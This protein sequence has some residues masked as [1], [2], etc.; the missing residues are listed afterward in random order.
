[1]YADIHLHSTFSDSTLSVKNIVLKA[2][3]NKISLIS[4]CD[5]HSVECYDE[6]RD[7]CRSYGLNYIYGVEI[8]AS[9]EKDDSFVH[10]LGYNPNPKN[11]KLLQLLKFSRQIYD[12]MSYRLIECLS[13]NIENIS[14]LK[15]ENFS[16]T[17]KF[18]GWKAYEYLLKNN[19]ISQLQEY[20][21]L[22]KSYNIENPQFESVRTVC[23]I[24][25]EAGGIA[26]L[27]HPGNT[28]P[29]SCLSD[30]LEKFHESGIEGI[31]CFYPRHNTEITNMCLKYCHENN[32]LITG[33]SD[34][35]GE[36]MK[37]SRDGFD[38][39]HNFKL[40]RNNLLLGNIKIY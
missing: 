23:S 24:I 38:G 20:F 21:K 29:Q 39:M 14:A 40:N 5:H 34:D 3:E 36:F 1:M 33:G 27:A 31:E 32:L 37:N 8:N 18:G 9:I 7:M 30:Y 25:K 19:I 28:F 16:Y 6:M 11:D 12:R 26:V 10:I 15:Y 35:H 17:G 4:I 2:I 13:E 22:L